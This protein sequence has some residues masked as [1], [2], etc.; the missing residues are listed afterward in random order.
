MNPVTNALSAK[1]CWMEST[2]PLMTDESKPNR[3]PPTA[4]A[5]ARPTTFRLI[6]A[7]GWGTCS[8]PSDVALR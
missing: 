3:N 1:W 5:V 7:V 4:A 2:A 6:A 8:S